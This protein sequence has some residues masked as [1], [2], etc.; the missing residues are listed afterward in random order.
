MFNYDKRTIYY[1]KCLTNDS[2]ADTLLKLDTYGN[3]NTHGISSSKTVACSPL[4]AQRVEAVEGAVGLN[5]PGIV[6]SR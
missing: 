2:Q 5:T 1:K 6:R 3:V 4:E